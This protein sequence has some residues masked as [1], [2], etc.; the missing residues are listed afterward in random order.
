MPLRLDSCGISWSISKTF[1]GSMDYMV[2]KWLF[3][4][5]GILFCS[6]LITDTGAQPWS[7]ASSLSDECRPYSRPEP[8]QIIGEDADLYLNAI[9][10]VHESSTRG[11]YGCGP[12]TEGGVVL[13]EAMR[14]LITVINRDDGTVNGRKIDGSLI[15]GIKLGLKIYDNCDYRELA[16]NHLIKIFPIV[17]RGSDPCEENSVLDTNSIAL[18]DLVGVSR[19]AR[20]LS[21]SRQYHLP[22]HA[23][24]HEQSVSTESVAKTLSQII[25]DLK[26]TQVAIIHSS[27]EHSLQIIKLLGQASLKQ[28]FCL[29]LVNTLPKFQKDAYFASGS[30]AG[31]YISLL[32]TV[33]SSTPDNV[34]IFVLGNNG[35]V[36]R[37]LEVM[38]ERIDVISGH[39]WLFSSLPDPTALE[40]FRN[41]SVNFFTL[42]LYPASIDDFEQYWHYL[43]TVRSSSPT[44]SWFQEYLST[45]SST[46]AS[47]DSSLDI[48]WRTNQVTPI[49]Q[50]FFVLSHALREAWA[51][52]CSSTPGLC[53]DL[54]KMSRKEFETDFLGEV[55]PDDDSIK[56]SIISRFVR[57]KPLSTSSTISK[58]GLNLA[59]TKLVFKTTGR[60]GIQYK[61][62]IAYDSE[63]E[64]GHLIDPSVGYKSSP[65]PPSGCE[66]CLKLRQSRIVD[67]QNTESNPSFSSWTFEKRSD[68]G[69]PSTSD[70]S[71]PTI[72]RS[73]SN[74]DPDCMIK[75]SL[76]SSPVAI[77]TNSRSPLS[78]A[79][80]AIPSSSV[81]APWTRETRDTLVPAIIEIS[82][83]W[84]LAL[85]I[86]SL[87]G[88]LFILINGFYLLLTFPLPIN[89]SPLDYLILSGLISLYSVNF[90][91]LSSPSLTI[92]LIR[93]IGMSMSYSL[94]LSAML[95]KVMNIW[96][97]KAITDSGIEKLRS[98]TP[99]RLIMVTGF[100]LSLQAIVT[101]I[102]IIIVPPKANVKFQTC[103]WPISDVLV[104]PESIVSL[105][106]ILI[107]ISLNIFFSTLAWK[108]LDRDQEPR[109]IMFSCIFI[110]TIWSIWAFCSSYSQSIRSQ[111]NLTIVC[112]NLLSATVI[113]AC[114][115]VRKFDLILRCPP[116]FHS[117]GGDLQSDHLNGSESDHS[118][119]GLHHTGSLAGS[120]YGSLIGPTKLSASL[121]SHS[122]GH[123]N[124]QST[125]SNGAPYSTT[126]LVSNKSNNNLG[127]NNHVHQS[128]SSSKSKNSTLTGT[129]LL[130]NGGENCLTENGLTT[131]KNEHA[132]YGQSSCG[133]STASSIQVQAED[134]YPMEVYEGAGTIQ[135]RCFPGA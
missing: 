115:Y 32:R 54:L 40:P 26:W 90:A 84:Y 106:Y 121:L 81:P 44:S 7:S 116:K 12:V 48:L 69:V 104:A 78:G 109:W 129:S 105:V 38:S 1:C 65:C 60:A 30:D 113:S 111:S 24:E 29:T 17:E 9:V 133:G 101:V 119:R 86:L 13:V 27:D 112:A 52:R 93:R 20:I 95:V 5:Y 37:L 73:I 96:R 131:Y 110:S 36:R 43:H 130:S 108:T 53:P 74:Y 55:N 128:N 83:G 35:S 22:I 68:S 64:K 6:S 58:D 34:P 14:W 72:P 11:I 99:S 71:D 19:D 120:Q 127:N 2:P 45:T 123:S 75:C 132:D 135:P 100:L 50:T 57:S 18:I 49:I 103:S 80:L 4:F 134:L 89:N 47:R 8:V 62:M 107:Q 117:N 3:I 10:S 25:E 76:K 114:L 16:L 28:R 77:A 125:L 126:I 85:A 97:L 63:T 70:M 46:I 39:Q 15:P 87:L 79:K 33:I 91:F 88:I 59:L 56:E 118:L 82:A 61:H 41:S 31:A 23:V 21:L 94:L 124:G 102:F 66:K 92:C 98:S 67:H 42:S 122:N 51:N